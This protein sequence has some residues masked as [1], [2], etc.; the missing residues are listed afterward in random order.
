MKTS[1]PV[2]FSLTMWLS[3]V[4]SEVSKLSSID[5]HR[6]RLGAEAVLQ[7]LEVVLAVIVVLIHHGDLGVR[8]VL[9]DVLRIDLGFALVVGLPSHGPGEIL[10]IVPLGGA[11]GDEQ[12]RHLLR[13]HVFVDRGIRRRS[14][15]IEHEQHFV[16]FDQLARLLHRLRR[17]VGVVIADEVDLAAVD[18]AGIVD[19]LEVGGFGLAD[20]AIGGSGAAIRHDVADLDFGIGGAGIVFFLSERAVARGGEHDERGR[21]NCESAGDNR[22][23]KSPYLRN[24]LRASCSLVD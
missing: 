8:A 6:G 2:D 21:G 13:I 10:R 11:G 23:S 1:A 4:G 19:L 12:L 3:T 18:A 14:Q 15:R 5:D 17:A 22:H 20:D 24:I 16:A 9:Q 7:T